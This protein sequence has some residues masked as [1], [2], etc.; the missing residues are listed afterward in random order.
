MSE[1]EMPEG[2]NRF[3]RKIRAQ[4]LTLQN[5][6]D[7]RAIELMKEMAEA[8]EFYSNYFTDS[9]TIIAEDVLKKFK[10]WK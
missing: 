5:S 2:W 4:G 9:K 6:T 10:D 8:L 3:E 1:M 7:R